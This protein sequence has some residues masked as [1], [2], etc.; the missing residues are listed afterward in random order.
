MRLIPKNIP[1]NTVLNRGLFFVFF[2]CYAFLGFS[3][4]E[5]AYTIDK[6]GLGNRNYVSFSAASADL[7][8]YGV[9]GAVTFT[10]A[11]GVYGERVVIKSISGTGPVA[12]VAFQ[13]LNRDSVIVAYRATGQSDA[14]TLELDSVDFITVSDITFKSESA[15]FAQTVRLTSGCDFNTLKNCRIDGKNSVDSRS[16]GIILSGKDGTYMGT[17]AKSNRFEGNVI[18]GHYAGISIVGKSKTWGEVIGNE[19][20]NNTVEG[21]YAYGVYNRQSDSSIFDGNIFL[22]PRSNIAIG[23]Y[24][25]YSNGTQ[26][27]RNQIWDYG[28]SGISVDHANVSYPKKSASFVNN[29]VAGES[30]FSGRAK[31]AVGF[32]LKSASRN[33]RVWHNSIQHRSLKRSKNQKAIAS[34][35]SAIRCYGVFAIDLRNNIFSNTSTA[36]MAHALVDS[37]STYSAVDF[38]NYDVSVGGALVYDGLPFRDLALWRTVRPD[39]NEYSV[40]QKTRFNGQYD[41][42]LSTKHSFGRGTL[43]DIGADIDGDARC[44]LAPSIGADESKYK[45]GVPSVSFAIADTVYLDAEVE[46]L[47]G[48]DRT[49]QED[50]R[51]YINGRFKSKA[52]HLTETFKK[53]GSQIISLEGESCEGKDSFKK[54]IWVDSVR[55][56]PATEFIANKNAVSILETVKFTDLSSHGATSFYWKMEPYWV[57]DTVRS[58]NMRAYEFVN[59]TDSNSRNPQV[60]FLTHGEYDICLSASNK[61]GLSKQ[62]KSNYIEVGDKKSLCDGINVSSAI[63]GKLFDPGGALADYKGSNRC[64]FTIK[65]CAEEITLVFKYLSLSSDYLRVFEG[66]D[67]TGIPLF[68]YHSRYTNGFTGLSSVNYFRDTLRVKG[69]NVFFE[70]ESSG[71]GALGFEMEWFGKPAIG[72]APKVVLSVADSICSDVTFYPSNLSSGKGN[73]YFWHMGGKSYVDFIDSSI[74]YQYKAAGNYWIKLRVENCFGYDEDSQL[75]TV[76]E[77]KSA[78]KP[79][80]KLDVHHPKIG[81]DVRLTDLSTIGSIDCANSWVWSISPATVVFT[82]NTNEFSQHPIVQFKDTGCYQIK[83]VVGNNFGEDSLSI[84]CAAEVLDICSPRV[85][86]LNSDI[87]ISRVVLEDIDRSSKMADQAYSD[88]TGTDR[89]QLAI[90]NTYNILVGRSGSRLN[91]INRAVWIDYDQDGVFNDTIEKI[92]TSGPDKLPFKIN[93]F[94]VPKGVKRG[95]ATMRVA[96]NIANKNNDACGPNQFGEYEDYLVEIIPDSKAPIVVLVFGTDTSYGD[97]TMAIEKCSPWAD[98]MVYGWDDVDD[99]VGV[100]ATSGQ[101][102][103]DEIGRYVL[104]YDIRDL[105]GNIAQVSV[106]VRVLPDSSAPKLILNGAIQDTIDVFS[107]FDDPGYTVSDNCDDTPKVYITSD[108]K[109][110]KTGSYRI[111]YLLRDESGN[112]TFAYRYVVVADR[113]APELIELLGEDTLRIQVNEQYNEYGASFIDN[114]D[115]V[116]DLEIL[117]SGFVDI[118]TLGQYNLTYSA[119]DKG[120]NK[121]L[122]VRRLVII[123]DTISPEVELLGLKEVDLNVLDKYYDLGAEYSDN[124]STQKEIKVTK[125]GSF[126]DA[127]G[128]DGVVNKLGQFE[129]TYVVTDQA[130]NSSKATRLINVDDRISPRLELLGP[131][132][133]EVPRWSTFEDPGYEL[134]DNYWTAEEIDVTTSGNLNM[135]RPGTYYVQYCPVDGSGNKGICVSRTVLVVDGLTSTEILKDDQLSVYP[136]PANNM[137]MLELDMNKEQSY[138]ISILNSVGQQLIPTI[139]GYGRLVRE[140]ID[141]SQLATG[142]YIIKLE[143]GKGVTFNTLH[144]NH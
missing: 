129:Y 47:N 66:T 79:A 94:T 21:Y 127:F 112:E 102:K 87:G 100:F 38:N 143:N 65:S 86:F 37:A 120:G 109:T 89:T 15:T 48:S 135:Q 141:C 23:Y 28:K 41:L 123:Q 82:Q 136:N 104:K 44:N 142:V 101:V 133:L 2:M 97:T 91:D 85:A 59:G 139:A 54:Y 29:M 83:L 1:S 62:C 90:G 78:P 130:G 35:S 14:A 57:F 103:V 80:F 93:S 9:S 98:P 115:E 19:F 17:Y 61:K 53:Y 125:T 73:Q 7:H 113:K 95:W 106:T 110:E 36:T 132:I 77:P 88:Y 137:V 18:S 105:S 5:G 108:L 55:V 13:G 84:S 11:A 12:R 144:V 70:F 42:H 63:T 126:I 3:Q 140:K 71:A 118:R 51:W 92:T 111:K 69:G 56:K 138:S 39:W 72:S 81:Q 76:I 67:S 43:L 24:E 27:L 107:D 99:S 26:F 60:V 122:L 58:I 114:Y 25:S 116:D 131:L 22:G 50:Y 52:I 119:T 16:A 49:F 8:K 121:S 64:N 31:A 117:V 6:T 40:V 46:F 20:S 134:T 4:L 45:R 10:V 96:V 75:V 33:I 30:K 124:Y 34:K 32:E 74:S 68:N 128:E